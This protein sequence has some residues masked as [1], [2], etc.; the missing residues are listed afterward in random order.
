MGIGLTSSTIEEVPGE[1]GRARPIL[2]FCLL[3]HG[4]YVHTRLVA[5]LRGWRL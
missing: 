3:R 5:Q 4:G 1:D 2:P